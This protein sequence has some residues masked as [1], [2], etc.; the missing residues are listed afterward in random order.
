MARWSQKKQMVI[1]YFASAKTTFQR[2][3][4]FLKD[5]GL[6]QRKIKDSRLR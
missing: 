2:K 3:G 1:S 6:C 4:S 5:R